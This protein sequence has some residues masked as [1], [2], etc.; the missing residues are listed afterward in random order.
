MLS[1]T[2][3]LGTFSELAREAYRSW[4]MPPTSCS[5]WDPTSHFP[6]HTNF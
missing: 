4:R 1:N 3:L 2:G 5:A 6:G